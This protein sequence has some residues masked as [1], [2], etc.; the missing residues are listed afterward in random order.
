M[1]ISLSS[2]LRHLTTVRMYKRRYKL[3]A[4][5]EKMTSF[6]KFFRASD[7]V[8]L[9]ARYFLNTSYYYFDRPTKI[10][11]KFFGEFDGAEFSVTI[12]GNGY[13]LELTLSNAG[14]QDIRI[15]EVGQGR[16]RPEAEHL[17]QPINPSQELPSEQRKVGVLRRLG[18]FV[19]RL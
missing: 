12:S 11:K 19:S 2:L 18:R 15:P 7:D 14:S 6:R 5:D 13:N 9:P 3:E 10:Y 17:G 8:T 16:F 4:T 1:F